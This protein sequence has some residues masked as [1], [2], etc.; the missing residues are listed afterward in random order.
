M[1]YILYVLLNKKDIFYKEKTNN[2]LYDLPDD[3]FSDN[4]KQDDT[5]TG[6]TVTISL[7]EMELVSKGST[8]NNIEILDLDEYFDSNTVKYSNYNETIEIVSTILKCRNASSKS[9]INK[10]WLLKYQYVYKITSL[11]YN[12]NYDDFIKEVNN[13]MFKEIFNYDLNRIGLT[14]LIRNKVYNLPLYGL[15]RLL[16]YCVLYN[17]EVLFDGI[18]KILK[19]KIKVDNN[20]IKSNVHYS[21]KLKSL[22]IFMNDISNRFDNKNVFELDKIDKLLKIKNY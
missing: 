14:K 22:I 2:K 21:N 17:D 5:V 6:L 3:I 4:K 1:L 12:N 7:K 19:Y 9:R 13:P 11:L 16:V 10:N 15:L 18:Y 8:S 20:S